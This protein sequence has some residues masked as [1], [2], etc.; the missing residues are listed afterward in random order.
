M[1]RWRILIVDD[2]E[3]MLEVCADCLSTADAEIVT[4]VDSTRALERVLIESW[5]L[6]I[7]DVRMP[8]MGGVELLR[9][10]RERDPMLSV[11]MITA[12][13]DVETAK[14]CRQHGA[15]GLL[16]KQVLARELL[17]SARRVLEAKHA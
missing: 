6:L 11:L 14:Q 9:L 5:D 17:A 7:A 12:F 15:V 8:G 1:A 13:P 2:E 4:E 3:G 10:A 16:S